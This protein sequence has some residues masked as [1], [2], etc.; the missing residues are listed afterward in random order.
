MPAPND[1]PASGPRSLTIL[2]VGAQ[3]DGRAQENGAWVNVPFTLAGETVRVDGAGER[4]KLLEVLTPSPERAAP[5]CKHFGACGGCTLQHM[6]PAPYA[7]F[8]RELIIR[9]LSARGL[10]ADVA[11]TWTTPPGSRRRAAFTAKRVGKQVVIGFHARKSHELVAI[12][13]CPVARAGIV[14]ALPRLKEIAGYLLSGK[15]GIGLLVTETA[16]GLD[17]HITGVPKDA[18]A[19]ARAEAASA[20]LRAG[21][22]RISIEG[23]DVLTERRPSLPAGAANLLPPPGGFLQASAEA[24]G[25]MERIV[26]E[27][28]KFA[29]SV[30]DLFSG[31]GTF[32]LR[33]AAE[34]SVL[35]AEGNA[36]AI[37]AL[38]D[39]VRAAH[40]LKPVR[41]EVR[42]LFRNPYGAAELSRLGGVVL[43]PPRAGAAAQVSE[44]ARS[45]V[46]R[47]AY[48]SCDPA[49]LARDLRTLVDGGYRI[50]RIHPIDQFL[51]SA[52]VEAVALLERAP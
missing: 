25:E 23:A 29:A 46:P 1:T 30:A 17:L 7:T 36:A 12:S 20:A 3:G 26:R 40:G 31:C 14:A 24:E 10:D 37:D 15:D 34:A 27:H 11:E 39:A 35:A 50:V 21:F 2:A 5:A 47:I 28:L 48:V 32:A 43:D 42:D 33:L 6:A 8:K 18:K 16:S 51:W 19:L 22:A 38:K 4:L 13:E 44:L 49:T 45:F 9:A 52:H 41:A